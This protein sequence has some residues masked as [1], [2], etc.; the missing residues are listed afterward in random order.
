VHGGDASACNPHSGIRG[1]HR[2]ERARDS[3]HGGLV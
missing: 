2:R 3:A 1:D